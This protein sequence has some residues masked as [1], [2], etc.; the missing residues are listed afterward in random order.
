M[1]MREK[2]GLDSMRVESSLGVICEKG[3]VGYFFTMAGQEMCGGSTGR[4]WEKWLGTACFFAASLFYP[5]ILRNFA[6]NNSV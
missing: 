1:M 2:T 6:Y 4:R 3:L 5:I